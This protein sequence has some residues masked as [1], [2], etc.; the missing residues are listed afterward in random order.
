MR[1]EHQIHH[2]IGLLQL[3]GHVL[4]LHHAAAHRDYLTRALLFAVV[5]LPDVSQN[6][7]LRV[8]AHRAGV[9]DDDVRLKLILRK[10]VAHLGKIAAYLLAVGLVLLAAVGVHHGKVLPPVRGE[11]LGYLRADILLPPYLVNSYF[12]SLVSHY[13]CF[14]ML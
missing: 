1:P 14:L 3:L 11:P 8:L 7:H 12:F 9:H 10:A 4:L 13:P 2:G 6:A 5:K